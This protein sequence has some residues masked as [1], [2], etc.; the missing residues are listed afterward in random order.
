MVGCEFLTPFLRDFIDIGLHGKKI[1]FFL[2]PKA[3]TD[4]NQLDSS[5]HEFLIYAQQL[6]DIFFSGEFIKSY[7][8]LELKYKFI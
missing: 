6:L 1:S 8:P 4:V 5:R 7:L 3:F 2:D